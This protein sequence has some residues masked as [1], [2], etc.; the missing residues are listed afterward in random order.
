MAYDPDV[1]VLGGGRS[2]YKRPEE[3]NSMLYG[4]G[5]QL[6]EVPTFQ[7]EQ[8]DLN[9][10]IQTGLAFAKNVSRPIVNTA[11]YA[12]NAP[13]IALSA[14]TGKPDQSLAQ[15]NMDVM[16]LLPTGRIAQLPKLPDNFEFID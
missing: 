10:P 7:H 11:S 6:E 1:P 9:D 12:L 2:G 4:L 16:A 5:A 15:S 14:L 3:S 8:Y 13:A